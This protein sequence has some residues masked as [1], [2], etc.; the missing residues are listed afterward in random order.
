MNG[1]KLIWAAVLPLAACQSSA[2]TATGGSTARIG[3]TALIDT[4][5]VS[6]TRLIEDSRCPALVRCIW[7]GRLRIEATIRYRGGSE[8]LHREMILGEAISLPEGR[9]TL[10]AAE[11]APVAGKA[12]PASAYRFTFTLIPSA[13][14]GSAGVGSGRC[15]GLCLYKGD[16]ADH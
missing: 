15:E 12:V 8:E 9:L 4:I 3:Q 13:A 6:P 10:A 2:M 11:P 14:S 5:Q 7:A 1:H 16:G